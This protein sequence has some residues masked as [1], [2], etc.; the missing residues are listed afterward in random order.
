M[1]KALSLLLALALCF[2]LCACAEQDAE[3]QTE[4][5]E[6][7]LM[8][9]TG[10]TAGS[11]ETEE[12]TA[13][14]EIH[15]LG[16]T[17]ETVSAKLTL[18]NATFT[19]ALNN[20]SGAT[21]FDPKEYTSADSRNPYVANDG[22]V[23]A[24][25]DVM[26]TASGR[27]DV[28]IDVKNFA[29]VEFNDTLY[30][31]TRDT[32]AISTQSSNILLLSGET[33]RIKGYV[34]IPVDAALN[35]DFNITFTLPKGANGWE[36][37]TFAIDGDFDYEAATA[38]PKAVLAALDTA[39]DDMIFVSKYAGNVNGAGSRK[40]AD[41]FIER[42][43]TCFDKLDVEYITKNLPYISSKIEEIKTNVE[44]VKDLLIEMGETNSDAKVS[45][46]KALAKSTASTIATAIA[47]DLKPY[48]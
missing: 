29:K 8:E 34:E 19:I 20:I 28:N 23:L 32:S 5:P 7:S 26:L 42:I 48:T 9:S 33:E 22:A 44:D 21:F 3:K 39:Y 16:D 2:G 24:Y 12:T 15:S 17:V 43:D 46:I 38:A 1:K 40:F 35:S 41:S 25:Y 13:Q 6:E 18:K 10:E 30:T 37:F 45:E 31:G 14:R 47:A 4:K 11:N 27:S 36:E